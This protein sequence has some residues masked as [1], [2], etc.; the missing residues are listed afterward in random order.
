MST[1][2][3]TLL[4]SAALAALVCAAPISHSPAKS[5]PCAVLGSLNAN[6]TTYHHVADCYKSIEYNPDVAKS[7]LDSLYT[8]YNDFFVFRDSALTPDLA[9]PFSSPPV[10]VIAELEKIRQTKYSSD[11]DFHGDVLSLACSLNDAHVNYNLDCYGSFGFMQPLALYAPVVNGRQSIRVYK[12]STEN[13]FTDCEVLEIEGKDATSYLQSWADNKTGFSKDAGVRLNN[14]LVR[15]NYKEESQTWTAIAGSFTERSTLPESPTL[16]YRLQCDHAKGAVDFTSPWIVQYVPS[17][18]T[19]SDKASFVQ[20]ICARDPTPSSSRE[21]VGGRNQPYPIENRFKVL[22]KRELLRREYEEKQ[23]AVLRKRADGGEQSPVQDFPDATFVAGNVTAVYQLKS[24]PHIGIL[25]VPTMTVERRVEVPAIQ[26][27]LTELA[28]RNV[29]N[30]IIDTSGNGGGDVAFASL[31]VTAFFPT[32]VKDTSAHLARFRDTPAAAALAGADLKDTNY[33]S[34]F[35]P[36][37]LAD[38]TTEQAIKTNIFLDGVNLT[39]N[40]RVAEYTKEFYMDYQLEEIDQTIK[41]PWSGDASKIT[42]LTDGQCGSAC[43]MF[44]ELM[45]SKHGVKAV[46]VGGYSKKELSMF[47]FAGASVFG[48]DQ[49][50]GEFEKLSVPP[51]LQ[52]LPYKGTVRVSM[53]EVYS[54]NDT[55][56]LEYNPSRY[57]AAHHIDYTPETARNHDQLW[58]AVAETAWAA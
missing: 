13:N 51:T 19:F 57:V 43:G 21:S 6:E 9:L 52:Y 5:D 47:S 46:A 1:L 22:H 11:F 28:N 12:D 2:T 14:V 31:L 58:G 4:L 53:I 26:A 18:N 39:V 17:A 45:V 3:K 23:R 50:V 8:L 48:L 56:P 32:Q 27:Y 55:I 33:S 36:E 49:L 41:Y 34:Y 30:I 20:N 24:K 16:T 35:D 7:T 15:Q 25:V 10:D 44:S 40:G 37:T 29:T 54:M 42:I 38:V